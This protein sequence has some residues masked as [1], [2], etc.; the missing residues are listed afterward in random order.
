L[1]KAD[2]VSK[3]TLIY[4]SLKQQKSLNYKYFSPKTQGSFTLAKFGAKMLSKCLHATILSVFAL[5]LMGDARQ[6]ET[7]LYVLHSPRKTR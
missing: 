6:T 4:A 1:S 2:K 3:A 5:T 7:N